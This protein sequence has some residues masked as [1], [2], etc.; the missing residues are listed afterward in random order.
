LSNTP[1]SDAAQPLTCA[2]PEL[3]SRWAALGPHA[4]A[5]SA[6]AGAKSRDRFEARNRTL[7][8]DTVESSSAP[9]ELVC[10][11][12][13]LLLIVLARCGVVGVL[14]LFAADAVQGVEVLGVGVGEG[15]EVLLGG[16]DLGVAHA[17][18][19]GLEVGAASQEP[20]GV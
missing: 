19:H 2:A 4:S 12:F 13:C 6:N 20:G 8:H 1:P 3:R 16:G 18:H 14:R 7:R 5:S 11:P 9:S 15:V 17:V 10:L